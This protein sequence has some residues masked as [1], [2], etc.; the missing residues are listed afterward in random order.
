MPKLTDSQ[1]V[2]LATAAE[3]PDGAVLPLAKSLKLNKG[4]LATVLK[5]L[6]KRRL[7]VERPAD[8]D[9]TAWREAGGQPMTLAITDAGRE[10]I[11]VEPEAAPGTSPASFTTSVASS[12]AGKSQN[13]S[14]GHS[15]PKSQSGTKQAKLIALL[16]RKRGA[17]IAEAGAEIGWQDHSVRGTISGDLKKKL[18]FAV[19]SEVEGNR[20][21]VYRIAE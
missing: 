12:P 18:G 17:T 7:L 19:T 1:L 6:V 13:L 21:R 8:K 4:A 9:D 15:A 3:R 11:G 20:G 2:I 5:S 16:R 10:A 14:S